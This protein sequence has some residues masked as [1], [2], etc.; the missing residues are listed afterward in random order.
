[1]HEKEIVSSA[2]LYRDQTDLKNF[3]KEQRRTAPPDC[4]WLVLI[5]TC[6]HSPASA[7]AIAQHVKEVLPDAA[8][9]GTS[10]A[11]VIHHGSIYTDQCL[12]HITRF[13]RT[14]PEIFRLSLDGK[15]P[16]KLAEEAAENFPADSRALFAFFTDQ[17]MHM[18]PFLQHL[19]QLR[20]HI[21]AAGGMISANTFGAFSFDE[22]GV[23]PHNAVFAVLCGITLRTWSGV[24]QG[25][26]A[27]GETYTITKTE[28]DSILEVDHQP[29]SQWFQQKLEEICHTKPCPICSELLMRFP[30]ALQQVGTQ[31]QFLSYSEPQNRIQ[32]YSNWL[33]AGTR[34]RMAYLSPL[35][36]V[37]ELRECCAE[38]N[39]TPCQTILAYPGTLHYSAMTNCTA[40]E[41]RALRSSRI[42][43][44]FL[45]GEIAAAEEH[46]QVYVGADT[47]FGLT[48]SEHD[49]LP[50][51]Q[52]LLDDLQGLDADWHNIDQYLEHAQQ[53][54]TIS[55]ASRQIMQQEI[56]LRSNT[57]L[58]KETELEN[59]VKF[60]FDDKKH[61]YNKICMIS[62]EK[63][64]LI[65][66]R[67][68]SK[69]WNQLMRENI[70]Q[71]IRTLHDTELFFY[72]N[73]KW[74]FFFT[75]EPEYPDDKFLEQAE[76]AF[77]ECGYYFCKELNITAVNAFYVVI[78]ETDLL[79][80]IQLC[81]SATADH[82]ARFYLYNKDNAETMKQMDEKLRMTNIISDAIL[83]DRIVPYFQP[84]RD[85][86]TQEI[87]KY[88]ALMRLSDKDHNIYA[89]GQFLEIAKDY[90]LYLQLSQLMIRKVLELFRDRTESVFLNLSAYDIS[91][92]A[93]RSML[94][95]LLSNLPQE[96]CGR[97]TF[98]IL[99]SEK[100]RDFNEMV[101][102]L[103]E[104][105]KFGVKIAIDDFGAGF[106]NFTAILRVNPDFIKIDGDL[107]INCDKDPMKQLCLQAISDIAKGIDA[108][109]I[110]EHVENSGEQQTVESTNIQY[111]QGYYFSKPLPYQ[112]LEQKKKD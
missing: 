24:V 38:L 60:K 82:N 46:N 106:S 49:Y 52:T 76:M 45:H 11:A 22:S 30:L 88:E 67:R 93:S 81:M 103:N 79:E 21:P 85:N 25:Q 41:L 105:R 33:P 83:Y 5:H 100:I 108:E 36:A 54:A 66:G 95:E 55:S 68:G 48:E 98:E 91:S 102:F 64:I 32:T 56:L 23:Y 92:E 1:M 63:G 78:G 43:G 10:A 15:T 19:E 34:F 7:V 3:L 59:L 110:A 26:E 107:I 61:R 65:S 90:H 96:A 9:L 29:A 16:E 62:I 94:Y 40:W 97:I 71:V 109:L 75:A 74:S 17:Y 73:D 80:K 8:V 104:I 42:C 4:S 87:T 28:Q 70:Q 27:F 31:S 39:T 111:T 6:C 86:R 89:P 72:C 101:N 35:T 18:Q 13:R 2:L 69:V 12:L 58:D 112:N 14:R 47:L 99:E 20:Q 37:A 53:Q 44:A 57:F 84:I 77:H 50:I 51:D